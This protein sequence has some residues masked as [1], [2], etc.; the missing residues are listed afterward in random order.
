EAERTATGP[1]PVDKIILNAFT[2][3]GKG[4]SYSLRCFL[5]RLFELP[6]IAHEEQQW[7]AKEQS[8]LDEWIENSKNFKP[9]QA[10]PNARDAERYFKAAALDTLLSIAPEWVMSRVQRNEA[11]DFATLPSLQVMLFSQYYRIFDINAKKRPARMSQ[12][13]VLLLVCHTS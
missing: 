2:P 5:D 8:I 11:P 10:A 12:M 4:P 13:Y 7:K 6:E 3:F 9:N 1:V